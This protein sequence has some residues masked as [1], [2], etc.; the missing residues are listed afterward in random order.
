MSDL[1]ELVLEFLSCF[2]D[3]SSNSRR[4]PQII[5]YIIII[6]ISVILI[7]I[8]ISMCLD[9]SSQWSKIFGIAIIV[10]VLIVGIYELIK[11][12]RSWINS[13]WINKAFKTLLT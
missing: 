11:I 3:F 9:N 5:K 7:G 8:G 6:L 12:Y 2:S 13:V 4:V 10:L 1:I